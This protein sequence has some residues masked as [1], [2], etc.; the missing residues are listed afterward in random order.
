M[1][2]SIY[3]CL[4][5]AI[6]LLEWLAYRE[7]IVLPLNK[8]MEALL[9]HF[10]LASR[11]NAQQPSVGSPYL[12]IIFL[13]CTIITLLMAPKLSVAQT[14]ETTPSNV[15][16]DEL[17]EIEVDENKVFGQN[18]FSGAF[19]K[20]QFA[21]FNPSYRV[22]IGDTLRIQ[23]W[24]AVETSGEQVV[25]LQG[26]I[27]IPQVGPVSVAGV[28]NK[29]LNDVVRESIGSVYKKDVHVYVSL[30]SSQPVRVFV[31]G[32][33]LRPGLYNGL[34]S[35]SLLS[36]LDR[37]GGIDPQRGSYLDVQ[38]RRDNA[39]VESFSLYD[40][41]ISGK[42]PLRQLHEG[43]VIVVGSRKSVIDFT[44]LVE[45][46]FQI[47]FADTEVALADALKI[48]DPS[49]IATHISIARNQGQIKEVEYH[50]LD[51]ALD[52]KLFLYAGDEVNIVSDKSRGSIGI[53][54]EGE[55]AGRAQYV[56]PYGARLSD[57]LA[58]IEPTEL[59]NLGA[60]QL[61]RESLAEKQKESLMT[62]LNTLQSQVLSAR[63]DTVEEANLRV[64]ESQLILQFIE[65][66]AQ[67]DPKGQVVLA[68]NQLAGDILLENNDK[69]VIPANS[70]LITVAGEVLFPSAV[71]YEST[72]KYKDY[73][74]LAGGFT[75]GGK[76]S[77]TMLKKQNGLVVQVGGKGAVS[78]TN[79]TVE[80]GDEILVLAAV[81]PKRMQHAKDVFQ[82]IY[83]L[84]LSAGVVLSI[85]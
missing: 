27:F 84:A 48:V 38:L 72:L 6:L 39:L 62:T 52:Q 78:S 5:I 20:Q 53:L 23:L 81:D 24:G 85:D 9:S 55:H 44:G 31:T 1:V 13:I 42:L 16:V 41:L 83:Q 80:A 33:V 66:A 25:D 71:L 76:K 21:G 47:E 45:N 61:F 50:R 28:L 75:Q 34:A 82:I 30:E 63:S 74:A 8:N 77:R 49:P 59:T 68:D 14:V 10:I 65:R 58:L 51:D 64:Q 56:L 46:P 69:I 19:G 29:E 26:N 7:C 15:A 70:K 57:L 36:Y 67:V 4:S 18:L 35:E 37:A 22:A 3:F 11:R 40:F 60:V 79:Y 54:V 12:Y 43:D 32:N 2:P 73:V 17:L